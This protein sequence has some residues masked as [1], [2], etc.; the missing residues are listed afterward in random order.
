MVSEVFLLGIRIL[1]HG[2]HSLKCYGNLDKNKFGSL[3]MRIVEIIER[4]DQGVTRP[5]ICRAENNALYYVKGRYAGYRALCCEW[6]AGEL[7]RLRGLPV[8]SFSILEVP[9][10][11]I[12]KSVREDAHELGP[13]FCFGS[14]MVENA[15]ELRWNEAL[16]GQISDKL[17]ADILLFDWWIANPD[18]ILGPNGG[19]PNLL[20]SAS[21]RKLTMIDH[22][23]AFSPENMPD[24]LEAFLHDHVF[25]KRFSARGNSPLGDSSQIETLTQASAEL[26]LFWHETK[27]SIDGMWSEMPEDWTQSPSSPSPE[28]VTK[29][30][31]RMESVEN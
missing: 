11:L 2:T 7:A 22:N 27:N 31:D 29:I 1:Q 28:E 23:L 18:R 4:S 3:L 9:T 26:T 24:T 14:L 15:D 8:A 6:I 17:R 5:F 25:G 30:L 13:G 20:W 16:R 10:L 21:E 19:N 12:S